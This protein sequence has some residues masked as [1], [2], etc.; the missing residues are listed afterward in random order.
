MQSFSESATLA[1]HA[2]LP[3][4]SSSIAASGSKLNSDSY[5]EKRWQ[6]CNFSLKAHSFL[7][8]FARK[9]EFRG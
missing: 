2:T 6:K 3:V 9:G 7:A 4:H 1:T 5:T 8:L